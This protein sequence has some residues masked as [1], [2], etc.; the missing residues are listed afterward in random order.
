MGNLA[1]LSRELGFHVTGSDLNSYPPMS[2]MLKAQNIE[3]AA[4]YHPD[5]LKSKPDLVVVGNTISR[6]NPEVNA[7]L[8]IGIDYTSGPQWLYE[9]I[10]RDRQVITVAG[11]HG[12]TTTSSMIASILEHAGYDPGYLIGGVLRNSKA[13]RIGSG[14]WFVVEGDEY[15]TAYFDKRSKFIHYRPKI[16]VLL[17]LE[18]DH[19]DIFES[20]GDIEKQ[21]EY[22]IRTLPSSGQIVSNFEDSRLQNTI[23]KSSLT[24]STRFSV[25]GNRDADWY[26]ESQT[27]DY[28]DLTFHSN[29]HGTQSFK[30]NIPGRHNAANAL[31]AV[32][33]A[34]HIGIQFETALDAL[35]KFMPVKR[36]LE[37]Y[38]S[39]RGIRIFDDFAHHPTAIR[40]SIDAVSKFTHPN[41]VF[42]VFEPRSNTMRMGFH[43]KNLVDAFE[44]ADYVFMY[45]APNVVWNDKDCATDSFFVF[46]SVT[47]LL[48]SLVSQLRAHDTVLIMSNG[49]FDN[50]QSRLIEGLKKVETISNYE[51]GQ[52]NE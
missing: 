21:F 3:V 4:G 47:S 11:T 1:L 42:A 24:P 49:G 6:S 27:A 7:M 52:V 18:F 45:R 51:L 10:L 50:I 28:S 16:A 32:S 23:T 38:E 12:K 5:N 40:A 36:R 37:E 9:N 20:I 34:C 35:T 2:E 44:S 30:W 31:A 17:N 41:R 48:D 25:S 15:D 26:A 33:T 8:D 14:E 43:G 46:D 19:A 13:A 29:V 39:V 22:L